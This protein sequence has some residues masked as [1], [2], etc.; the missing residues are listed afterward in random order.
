MS[1]LLSN[2][3]KYTSDNGTIV[4]ELY[5]NDGKIV[6]KVSDDGIGISPE[7]LSMIFDKFYRSEPTNHPQ[8]KGTGLG[9]SIVKDYVLFCK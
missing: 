8:I 6:F 1:N 9:L 7:N 3:I 4:V 5:K 2:S